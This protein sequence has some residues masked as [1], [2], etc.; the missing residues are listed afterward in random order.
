M[1]KHRP[2]Y[3]VCV[4]F[5]GCSALL[6]LSTGKYPMT[7]ATLVQLC[8]SA[9][10]CKTSGADLAGPALV[11]WSVRL[12]R[13][14]MA[15]LV[16]AGIS[17]SGAVFQGLFK[18]PL[19]SPG[20]LGVTS[21]ANFGAALG[22]LFFAGSV[23]AIQVS[24]FAWGLIAVG[25]TCQIGKRG[26]RSITTLVLAGVIVS[27][28]FMAGLSYIKC[29]ADPMGQL[30]AI[31]FW[32]M[33]SFNSISWADVAWGGGLI[34]PGLVAAQFMSWGL[35]PLSLGEEEALSLG[36]NVAKRRA[37][38]IMLATLMVSAATAPCG[39]IGWVGLL[40]PHMARIFTGADHTRLIPVSALF[41]AIF[42]LAMDTLART[43]P[44]GEIP[45]GI[46]TSVIGAPCFGLL[47]IRNKTC[48]WNNH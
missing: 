18:N 21:G 35:N 39:T 4:L 31:V 41:G 7:P 5:L 27:A 42:M 30:P 24:A 43:L 47:L 10:G 46:L 45:V 25:L 9:V 3:P 37:V 22:L 1:T 32:T 48:I 44:G 40:I 29:K 13:I 12:P 15:V 20:I 16:G 26:D 33:G 6:A 34:A 11:L 8:L 17:V 14:L 28:L 36:L 19:V 38:Y 23:W 2:L